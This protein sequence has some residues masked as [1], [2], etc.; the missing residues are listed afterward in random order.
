MRAAF[1][2]WPNLH[3]GESNARTLL[4]DARRIETAYGDLDAAYNSDRFA[5]IRSTLKY[6][7]N[8]EFAGRPNPSKLRP[9]EGVRLSTLFPAYRAA[10]TA[11][12]EFREGKAAEDQTRGGT[13]L[14]PS[15]VADDESF[16][17]VNIQDARHRILGSI[18]Q[19]RG[20]SKFR[21]AL[22]VACDGR[23]AITG[24][25]VLDVLEASHIYPYRGPETNAMSNGLLLRA[26]LHTLFDCGLIAVDPDSSAILLA[27]SL[28]EGEYGELSGQKMRLPRNLAERPS[29]SALSE[30][31]ARRAI[32]NPPGQPRSS[33][34]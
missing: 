2:E 14:I 27:P 17:P 31:S 21:D 20:Q 33:L 23:C 3:K 29:R 5:S 19:R 10:L 12:S 28:R 15:S 22:V 6:S 7:K 30:H 1:K 34:D 26:D 11:Y 32:L 16:D 4:S 18:T 8:D 13:H 9:R 25:G 24:C